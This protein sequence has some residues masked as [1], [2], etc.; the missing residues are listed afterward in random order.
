MSP[1]WCPSQKHG[2]V[3][4]LWIQDVL[5]LGRGEAEMKRKPGKAFRE[6]EDLSEILGTALCLYNSK[7]AM[8]CSGFQTFQLGTF[9]FTDVPAAGQESFSD[10]SCFSHFSCFSTAK[11]NSPAPA[12]SS[13]F[14][15]QEESCLDLPREVPRPSHPCKVLQCF[16]FFPFPSQDLCEKNLDKIFKQG[17]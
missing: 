16:A 1:F 8:H 13:F 7:W 14:Q 9:I 5:G 11:D 3:P 12:C 2:G 4:R 10:F 6:W 17:N 15:L